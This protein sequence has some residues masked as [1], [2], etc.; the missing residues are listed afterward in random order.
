MGSSPKLLD[1]ISEWIKVSA[2]NKKY[3]AVYLCSLQESG[4][5]LP[6]HNM[7]HPPSGTLFRLY[8]TSRPNVYAA[9]SKNTTV[10]GVKNQT[11]ESSNSCSQGV[12]NKYSRGCFTLRPKFHT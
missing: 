8:F 7:K 11:L 3:E 4:S 2:P 1:M 10:S 6:G 5:V 12:G 9:S